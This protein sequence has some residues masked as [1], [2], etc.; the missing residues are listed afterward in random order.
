MFVLLP[1]VHLLDV[2]GPAQVFGT[3]ADFGQPYRLSY[4]AEREHVP[5]AQG[6]PLT[7][8]SGDDPRPTK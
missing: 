8:P 2:A 7:A 3:A 5:S 6:L 1:E 4:V